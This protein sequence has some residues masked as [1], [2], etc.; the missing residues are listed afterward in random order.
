MGVLNNTLNLVDP[1]LQNH[2]GRVAELVFRALGKMGGFT[3]E[4]QR[5][6]C[7]LA[8]IHDIG[9]YKTDEIDRLVH[10]ET[11]RIW[12]HAIYG[13]LFVKNLPPLANLAPIIFFHHAICDE[14][15]HV[16]ESYRQL[17]QIFHV[18]DRI[19]IMGESR[20]GLEREIYHR[21]FDRQRGAKYDGRVIDLFDAA[22]FDR[23]QPSPSF[24]Y[25]EGGNE[26]FCTGLFERAA[27]HED[28]LLHYL[29]MLVH[30]IDFRSPQT[31]THTVGVA[32]I[33]RALAAHFDF[34]DET[35]R[36]I[37]F[38]SLLHD[39]GKQGI[40]PE[41]LEADR[42]LEPG[43]MD[44]M[45][46]HVRLSE[47]ILTGYVDPAIVRIAVRHH[48]KLNGQGYHHGLSAD[49][50]TLPER[51]V[52]V[53]DIASALLGVRS[54]KGAFSKDKVLGIM[55]SM[56]SEGHLDPDIVDL[57][58]DN[59]DSIIE[60]MTETSGDTF[61]MYDRMNRDYSHY[62]SLSENFG[63]GNLLALPEALAWNAG[64][65]QTVAENPCSPL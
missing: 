15:R 18:A 59:M 44:I 40:P 8:W 5:D 30:C 50:L 13:Y 17:A 32:A 9:A 46:T 23:D 20:G 6:L 21:Y 2:G 22:L 16:H 36:R 35:L 19:D 1:R 43:E 31:V 64:P 57:A 63:K 4:Q 58:S 25:S 14:M 10:F 65:G 39:L 62:L 28:E 37:T 42:R 26:G 53:A 55:H 11:V 49:D 47:E 33:A 41:I 27:F 3:R 51:L 54:Y 38:G 34:D 7:L 61:A 24:I 56:K 45:R 52:A 12:E 48:E 29:N 60:I